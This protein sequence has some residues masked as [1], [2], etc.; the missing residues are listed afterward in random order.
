MN[1]LT[2]FQITLWAKDDIHYIPER[3]R[4]QSTWIS[5]TF[6]ST[7]ARLGAFFT[8]GLRYKVSMSPSISPEV[9]ELIFIGP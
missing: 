5:G 2:S 4:V 6:C 3:Y 8:G 9:S 1:T 7:G